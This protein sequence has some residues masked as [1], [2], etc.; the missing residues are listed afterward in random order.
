MNHRLYHRKNRNRKVDRGLRF[1]GV[2]DDAPKNVRVETRQA[3][4]FNYVAVWLIFA[5]TM[6]SSSSATLILALVGPHFVP[7]VPVCGLICYSFVAFLAGAMSTRQ[8]LSAWKEVERCVEKQRKRRGTRL[9]PPVPEHP[10]IR[11][12]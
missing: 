12:H 4:A 11:Y 5:T 10:Y 2:R 7:F 3:V 8:L 9:M 1:A 6:L